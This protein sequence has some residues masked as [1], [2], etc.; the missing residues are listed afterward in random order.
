MPARKQKPARRPGSSV[1]ASALGAPW[2]GTKRLRNGVTLL[3]NLR[4][5]IGATPEN[6][7]A[8][9][10]QFRRLTEEE[11]K[12]CKPS[13]G[14]FLEFLSRTFPVTEKERRYNKLFAEQ[15]AKALASETRSAKNRRLNA[16]PAKKLRSKRSP[17]KQS[18]SR[19]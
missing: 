6:E 18:T 1:S 5:F 17:S 4:A 19:D 12:Q 7:E 9:F 11:L 2:P 16:R 8:R 3:T 14:S 13:E 15:E 10:R